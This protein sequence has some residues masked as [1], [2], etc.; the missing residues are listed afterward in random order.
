ML[1]YTHML[2][3]PHV[4]VG[5]YLASKFP[6][7]WVSIPLS[8]ASHFILDKVPHW[9]PHTYTETM[10]NGRPSKQTFIITIVD[11]GLAAGLGIWFANS[12]LPDTNQA[13]II[14]ASSFAS[15]LPDVSKYPFFLFKETRIGLY[16]KWVEYERKLQVDTRSPFWGLVTQIVVT[17]AALYTLRF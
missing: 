2:E 9:N 8:F 12:A 13:F 17:F 7:P 16:K 1:Y 14:L 15:V 10:K 3:T 5:V 6:N 11:I 4:A